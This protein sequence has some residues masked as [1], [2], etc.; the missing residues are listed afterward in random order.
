MIL[1]NG[2]RNYTSV[3]T[4]LNLLD[5]TAAG[6]GRRRGVFN[7]SDFSVGGGGSRS[8]EKDTWA[9]GQAALRAVP[10]EVPVVSRG[11]A[12]GAFEGAAEGV[13]RIE[14]AL[15]GDLGEVQ[16]GIVDQPAGFRDPA[17]AHVVTDAYAEVPAKKTAKVAFRHFQ[18][19]CQFAESEVFR[20]VAEE[21]LMH[22]LDK[23]LRL[24]FPDARLGCAGRAA[25]DRQEFVKHESKPESQL[26]VDACLLEAGLQGAIHE[27]FE[28][29]ESPRREINTKVLQRCQSGGIRHFERHEEPVQPILFEVEVMVELV[30]K[31]QD[32]LSLDQSNHLAIHADRT[33]GL[34]IDDEDES[35]VVIERLPQC[36]QKFRGLAREQENV[37]RNGQF[38]VRHAAV[39]VLHP[40]DG[41]GFALESPEIH[42]KS[43]PLNKRREGIFFNNHAYGN[44]TSEMNLKTKKMGMGV[45]G[46]GSRPRHLVRQLLAAG[47]AIEVR[48][49]F[50]PAPAAR[51][52]ALKDFGAGT[53]V[54]SSAEELVEAKGV[55]WVMVASPNCFHKDHVLAALAAGKHVFCE[56]PLATTAEDCLAIRDAWEKSGRRFFFGF[57]LRYSPFYRNL[58]EILASGKIGQILSFEFNETLGFN[59]GG[60]IMGNWRRHR[61]MAGTHLLEKC[62]HDIDLANWF[63]ASL[64]VRAASF[65]GL[66]FF[67]PEHERHIVRLG[68]NDRGDQAY[69]V[70]EDFGRVNPFTAHKSIVDH[71]VAILEYASGVKGTFHTNCNAGI[72]E[73]RFYILGSEGAI[74]AD[75]LSGKLEYKPVGFEVPTTLFD[76]T[77][78]GGHHGGDEFLLA[79]FASCMLEQKSPSVGI[80]EGIEAAF[81]CFGIDEALDAGTVVNLLPRWRQAGIDPS[82][83]SGQRRCSAQLASVGP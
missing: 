25:A 74:R 55:D 56:K 79:D 40:R 14:A 18:A 4:C 35:V 13:E 70:W 49:L 1:R 63:T 32:G 27:V 43:I 30:G 54:C 64:P 69:Q 80:E 36:P 29:L 6:N 78:G 53:R 23:N 15:V 26:V 83:P 5:G 57:C 37:V 21:V 9:F 41:G 17:F 39:V 67:R 81:A 34:Q 16:V 8:G 7:E 3:R 22:A 61:E 59:H 38:R 50:D 45:I 42:Q 75:A 11:Y 10:Y 33:G 51:E 2:R 12:V 65:G 48:A 73:R 71:Q 47:S 77:S 62:C 72:P 44:L 28:E 24:S 60:Y 58:H 66:S 76:C 82:K 52:A 31:H 19:A 46:C 20:H 68:R